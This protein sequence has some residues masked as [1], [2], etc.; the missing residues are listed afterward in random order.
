MYFPEEVIYLGDS[1]CSS[2]REHSFNPNKR[3]A[4]CNN[5]MYK[6]SMLVDTRPVGQVQTFMLDVYAESNG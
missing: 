4:E 2:T 3:D 1:N 6:T 5:T